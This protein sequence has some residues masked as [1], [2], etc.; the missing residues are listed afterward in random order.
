MRA[1]G[2][3]AG[4]AVRGGVRRPGERPAI[5]SA[6]D[7][8]SRAIGLGAWE[9]PWYYPGIGEYAPL[10]ERAGLEVTHAFLFD[11]P[12]PL[13]G[14]EGLR[15]WVEMFVGGLVGRVPPGDRGFF[16]HVE[17]PRGRPSI[18]TATGSPITG[19]C[20]SWLAGWTV[21]R[22]DQDEGGADETHHRHP[23][24]A[25]RPGGDLLGRGG[26]AGADVDRVG[27]PKDY[28]E[29]FTVLRRVNRAE[30]QQVVTVYGN[31]PAASI[32]RPETCPIPTVRSS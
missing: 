14:E 4:R 18:A 31:E 26:P 24:R 27:F 8:A 5:V 22:P 29:K 9:H 17:E 10:L 2:P 20:A 1:E 11:R 21:S 3:Q 16:R 13:E 6:L 19:G 7:A 30:K 23:D 28:R 25:G 15:N 12:T 32:E